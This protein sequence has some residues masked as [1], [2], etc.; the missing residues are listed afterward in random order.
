MSQ[1]PKIMYLKTK[2]IG[3]FKYSKSGNYQAR[4]KIKGKNYRQTFKNI[5]DAIQWRNTFNGITANSSKAQSKSSTSTLAYVWK[6]YQELHLCTL[7]PQSLVKKISQYQLLKEIE[8]FEMGDIN[9]TLMSEWIISKVEYY[10]KAQ[11]LGIGSGIHARY[12]MNQELKVLKSLYTWYKEEAEFD[13][14][15]KGVFCPV[16]NRHYKQGVIKTLRKKNKKIPPKQVLRVFDELEP[17]YRD[18]AITQFL[19]ASRI[20]E[21][22][23]IQRECIDFDNNELQIR[24]SSINNKSKKFWYLSDLTKTGEERTV[25]ITD[26]LKKVI[27]S[28]LRHKK[29]GCNFLFHNDGQ[30]L[31]YGMVLRKYNQA[32]KKLGLEFSGTHIMR[33]GCA[34]LARTLGGSLD[35]AMAMTGHKDAKV[36]SSYAEL[37]ERYKWIHHF[38][39]RS[40]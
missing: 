39:S 2:H 9:T 30:P 23:G 6:R 14:E 15:S 38:K 13:E 10:K 8:L 34:S 27:Q 16:K 12:S 5:R 11:A 1:E 7:R 29:E 17:L 40:I 3:I 21:T 33:H 4:K 24:F 26:M 37:N 20:G 28:R 35:S 32:T 31:D 19:C 22:L 36:A 18:L 25:I